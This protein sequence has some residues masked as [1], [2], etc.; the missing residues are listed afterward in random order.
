MFVQAFLPELA[1]ETFD[2]GILHRLAGRMN[3]NVTPRLVSLGIQG[4]ACELWPVVHGEGSGKPT[5][6]GDPV[7]IMGHAQPR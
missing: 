1:V 7:Q 2:I 4:L 6:R 5:H 3:D